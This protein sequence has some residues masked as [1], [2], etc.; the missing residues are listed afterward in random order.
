MILS[1]LRKLRIISQLKTLLILFTMNQK[2]NRGG[3][4]LKV[5]GSVWKTKINVKSEFGDKTIRS[6]KEIKP[7]EIKVMLN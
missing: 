4:K 6:L 5:K 1:R 7:W 3:L 2:G